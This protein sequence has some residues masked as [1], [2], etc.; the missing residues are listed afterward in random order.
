MCLSRVDRISPSF[1]FFNFCKYLTANSSNMA[2][3]NQNPLSVFQIDYR[4]H[5]G[6]VLFYACKI[7][8]RPEVLGIWGKAKYSYSPPQ[9][10]QKTPSIGFLLFFTRI[11]CLFC[12]FSIFSTC[13]NFS[14]SYL[15][16]ALDF[17]YNLCQLIQN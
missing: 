3:P 15:H 2:S 11:L 10:N 9:Q 12:L 6:Y 13:F 7:S 4:N 14:N 1:S 8:R 16:S 5:I 17:I